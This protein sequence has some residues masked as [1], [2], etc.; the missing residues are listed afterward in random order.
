MS[1]RRNTWSLPVHVRAEERLVKS[2]AEVQEFERLEQQLH[3]MLT[4]MSELSKKKA[5]DGLNKFKLKLVNVLMEGINRFLGDQ[6]PF[7]EFETFDENDLPTNS[8]VVVMLSQYAAAVFQFRL[9]NTEG[10]DYKWWWPL[11]GKGGSIPDQ[12]PAIHSSTG[13]SNSASARG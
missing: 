5:N 11:P 6:R 13:A 7:K 9:E 4:E 3:S 10:L 1:C 2:E 8:D 12:E